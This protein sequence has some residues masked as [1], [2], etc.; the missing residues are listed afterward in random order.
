MST[1]FLG[2]TGGFLLYKY[3]RWELNNDRSLSKYNEAVMQFKENNFSKALNLINHSMEIATPLSNHFILKGML[4]YQLGKYKSAI[5]NIEA[6]INLNKYAL[7]TI[8]DKIQGFFHLGLSRVQLKDYKNAIKDFYNALDVLETYKKDFR[9]SFTKKEEINIRNCIFLNLG[10]TMHFLRNDKEAINN[11]EK[12]IDFDSAFEED[13]REW[14]YEVRGLSFLNEGKFEDAL[15][16]FEKLIEINQT[17]ENFFSRGLANYSLVK[18]ENAIKDFDKAVKLGKNDFEVFF[19]RGL[20]KFNL[21]NYEDAIHDMD[22]AIAKDICEESPLEIK[23]YSYYY[24]GDFY[25]ARKNLEEVLIISP[26]NNEVREHL[27]LIKEE[28][29]N[30]LE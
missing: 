20:S 28:F 5:R 29:H 23:G 12:I 25:N 18:Y 7:I 11:L 2:L 24:L 17:S 27:K 22:Y 3:L 16:D 6:G 9:C 10:A 4:K 8:H 26:H 1:N 13:E 19:K 15:N 21:E 14:S 30:S